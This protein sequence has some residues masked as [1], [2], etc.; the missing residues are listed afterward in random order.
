MNILIDTNIFI[1]LEPT[2]TREAAAESPVVNDLLQIARTVHSC[3]FVHP[4]IV[5]DINRDPQTE[6]RELHLRAV[7]KYQ[8]L[9]APPDADSLPHEILQ[10]ALCGSNDWVDNSLLASVYRD[11]CDFLITEDQGI[12]AKARKLTLSSRVLYLQDALD[13]L[14]ALA[15]RPPMARPPNV[16]RCYFHQLDPKEALFDSLR[17][18]YPDFD[19]W[20]TRASRQHRQAFVIREQTDKT[21]AAI[22]A[23]K[24][25]ASLPGGTRGKVLKLCTFKVSDKHMGR[26]YGELLLSS[27]CDYCCASAYT[28]IYFTTF[29]KHEG[30]VSFTNTFGFEMAGKVNDRGELA[31]VKRVSYTAVDEDALAPVDF[32]RA[33]GPH[34]VT[35]SR[36]RSFLVPVQPRFVHRLWPELDTAGQLFEPEPCGNSIRKA[37]LC[38]STITSLRPGDNLM[39]YRSQEDAA[40]VTIGSVEHVTHSSDAASVIRRVGSRTVYSMEQVV[41]LCRKPTLAILFRHAMA[42]TNPISLAELKRNGV[43]SAAPQSVTQINK[44]FYPWLKKRVQR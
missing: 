34:A 12:H 24:Q 19:D 11:A 3:I 1:P 15:D 20:F 35:F 31:Y 23:L 22:A 14:Y 41:A 27:V 43:V 9:P 39:F 5:D 38:H 36:N 7:S 4:S 8:V 40:I 29:S 18:D 44:E 33:F 37:Y 2:S 21:I 42:V 6:R 28:L 26:R 32:Y 16:E 30:L 17:E 13:L 10:P 25:E